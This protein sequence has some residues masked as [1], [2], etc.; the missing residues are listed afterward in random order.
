ML[1]KAQRLF[2]H[3]EATRNLQCSRF[4]QND[5]DYIKKY[6]IKRLVS[7]DPVDLPMDCESIHRRNYFPSKAA[8]KEEANFPIA[9]A[10]IVYKVS[11]ITLLYVCLVNVAIVF[12][13]I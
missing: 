6:S 5:T 2:V 11:P 1:L 7:K 10:K 8:S 12:R 9:R 13:T 4:F 3:P